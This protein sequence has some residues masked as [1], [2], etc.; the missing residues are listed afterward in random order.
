MITISSR[1]LGAAA[2]ER[3]KHLGWT[4][5]ELAAK[6]GA[7]RLWVSQFEA[8]KTTAH[9][10]LVLRALRALGLELHVLE[11]PSQPSSGTDPRLVDLDALIDDHRN[12]GATGG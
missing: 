8:G 9:V 1:D 2:R 12:Q 10:G 11:A 5:N 3:R 7:K 4:Q 6:I